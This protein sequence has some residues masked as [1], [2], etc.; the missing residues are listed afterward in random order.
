MSGNKEKFNFG[1]R[2]IAVAGIINA[3]G[4]GLDDVDSNY[5]DGTEEVAKPVGQNLPGQKINSNKATKHEFYWT[6]KSDKAVRYFVDGSKKITAIKYVLTTNP[7]NTT[8][9]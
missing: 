1:Y 6:S 8:H 4:L 5:N 3:W 7:N 9:C 2:L